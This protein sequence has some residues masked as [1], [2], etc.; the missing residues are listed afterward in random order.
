MN[1][2]ASATRRAA[3]LVALW[4]VAA[5]ASGAAPSLPARNLLVE[6]RFVED[7]SDTR[8][9]AHG[10]TSATVSSNGRV[11][12]VGAVAANSGSLRQ[13]IDAQ[14]RVL[15]L[16]GARA[17]LRLAQGVPMDDSE[18]VWTP[19]GPGGAVRTKWVELV[20]GMEVWP[21]WPG[22]AAPVML[23]VGVQRATLSPRSQPLPQGATAP[24]LNAFT[25][26]QA[27][28]GEWVELAQ[29]Q[30]RQPAV[31]SGGFNA[32]TALRQRSLQVRVSLPN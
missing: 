18:V 27:P 17:S 13:G 32:A 14:Q 2:S 16:N 4:V 12:A 8:N 3:C 15:V 7:A 26:V 23:E 24:Q 25:T 10:R 1:R 19:W 22:G 30:R 21:R 31:S 20:N 28:L 6:M 9:D 29:L 5:I 11:D